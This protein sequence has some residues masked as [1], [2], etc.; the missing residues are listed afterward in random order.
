MSYNN[1]DV[2]HPLMNVVLCHNKMKQRTDFRT[3]NEG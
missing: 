2:T 1:T 3:H